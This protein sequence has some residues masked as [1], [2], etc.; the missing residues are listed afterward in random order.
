MKTTLEVDGA[1]F[2]LLGR[3]YNFRFEEP[4]GAELLG[5]ARGGVDGSVRRPDDRRKR[6]REAKK[7]RQ[8]DDKARLREELKR[9][10]NLKKAEV[11]RKLEL[12]RKVP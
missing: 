1:T 6:R 5:H 12:V 8:D 3:R 2:R 11:G 7:E 10:K 4:A 9:L